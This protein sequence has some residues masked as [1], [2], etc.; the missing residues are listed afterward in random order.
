[1]KYTDKYNENEVMIER[2]VK[3]SLRVMENAKRI[4]KTLELSEEDIN[5][6]TLI[7]VLHDIGRFE[8]QKRA[9]T[10]SDTKSGIDHGDL[11]AEILIKEREIEK[12]VVDTKYYPIIEKAVRN[13]NKYKIE[14]GLTDREKLFCFIAR[15]ADKK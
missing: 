3:H 2:K 12:Y 11:G 1:M 6:A 10:Y 9:N 15:D 13:H 4:A 7:G 14:E 8:Q 5:L